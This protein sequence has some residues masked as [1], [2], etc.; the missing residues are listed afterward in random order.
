M[1]YSRLIRA[2]AGVLS[3]TALVATAVT[4]TLTPVRPAA[5]APTQPTASP[6]PA[7]TVSCPSTLNVVAHEDDDLLFINPSV[8]DDITAGR[9]VVT[10]FVTAGDAG[11]PRS[12]WAGREQGSMDAYA[13]MA[14]VPSTWREDT[15]T[16]AG[17]SAHRFRLADSQITLLFLRLP[18]AHGNPDRPYGTLRT[19]WLG[20]VPS[21][22]TLDSGTVYTRQALLDTL[23][24]AMNAYRPGEIRTLDYAHPYGDGDHEDHHTVGYMTL[25]AQRNYHA[26]HRIESY[27]GYPVATHPDN[28]DPEAAQTKLNYFLAYVPHDTRVCQLAETCLTSFYAPRFTH[29]IVTASATTR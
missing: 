6:P 1:G 3:A 15:I 19:L 14:R 18:D 4:S 16:L 20:T 29:R 26:P 5:A 23:T 22:R 28:L 27:M 17:H 13:A 24:A 11:R 10:L 21:L 9:C 25:A 7:V 2:A 12:Y 8:S